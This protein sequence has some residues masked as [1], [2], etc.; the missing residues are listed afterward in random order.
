MSNAAGTSAIVEH[1]F[2]DIEQQRRAGLLGM[3]AFLATEVLFFGGLIFAY[4]IYRILH[5]AEFRAGSQHLVM[6]LGA[7]NTVVLLTSSLTMALAVRAARLGRRKT[8]IAFLIC[9]AVLGSAFLCVKGVEYSIDFKEG[10]T[11]RADYHY[12]G[13]EVPATLDANKINLF[14][15]LY[16]AMTGL[17][18]IHMIVGIG[19]LALLALLASR[20]R[21]TSENYMTVEYAGLYWHF[22][23]IVWLFLFPMLYLIGHH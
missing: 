5:P 11:P 7:L 16:Y 4:V 13:T 18:G 1:Q 20:G 8:L 15:F 12:S 9:T 22:V 17:H 21:F 10:L 3:W 14:Y 6:S 23:D 19:M 2:D